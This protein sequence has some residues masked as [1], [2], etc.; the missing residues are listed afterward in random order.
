MTWL[1]LRRYG[2]APLNSALEDAV[3]GGRNWF[4]KPEG[5]A[6]RSRFDSFIFRSYKSILIHWDKA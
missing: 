3:A 6:E 2:Q 5:R 4:A 1:D